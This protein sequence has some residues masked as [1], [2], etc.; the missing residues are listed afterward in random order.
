MSRQYI[1]HLRDGAGLDEVYLAAD[2]QLRVNKNG[3]P[4]VQVEL[5]DRTGGLVGRMWN[6]GES[7][8]RTFNVGDYVHVDGK[9]QSFQGNLQII[10]NHIER[11]EDEKVDP[12]DF[13]ARSPADTAALESKLRVFLMK[14]TN[15]HLKALA[16]CFLMDDC[17]TKDF[18]TCPAGVKLHHAYVGGLLEHTVTMMEMADKV[19]PFYSGVDRDQVLMGLYLHDIGKTRELTY[20]RA[21]GYGDE[22]QLVGHI[23]L[24]CEMLDEK[25]AEVPKLTNEPLPRELLVRLK[26]IIL[27]H[28][29][30]LEHGSPKVPMTAEAMLIHHIDIMD[31]RMHMALRDLR[32][33]AKNP[34]AWTP[35]NANLQRRFY[36]GGSGGELYGGANE[37]YD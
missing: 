5:R 25:A 9:V 23:T 16:E 19:V 11:V 18:R 10:I 2:K 12:A 14:L 20:A 26:H 31:T 29:G 37:T 4:Y 30:M 17:I 35:Y 8:Y 32:D 27:S 36:K 28:H 7:V 24:G 6:A 1:E 22:G 21:F 33:D 13:M 34:T 15:P 3:N